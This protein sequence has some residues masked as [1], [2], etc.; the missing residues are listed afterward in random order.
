MPGWGWYIVFLIMLGT[1]LTMGVNL[2][3][4]HA[5]RRSDDD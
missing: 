4:R 2:L 3:A 1:F 5:K